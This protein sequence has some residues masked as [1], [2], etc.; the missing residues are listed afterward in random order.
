MNQVTGLLTIDIN[1]VNTELIRVLVT[2]KSSELIT[3]DFRV[4][5]I[6]LPINPP[7]YA[8][9]ITKFYRLHEANTAL[10]DTAVISSTEI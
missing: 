1:I 10:V 6:C 2:Y 5:V 8:K 9:P 4:T 3:N 7:F